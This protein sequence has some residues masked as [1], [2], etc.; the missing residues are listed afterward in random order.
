MGQILKAG[1]PQAYKFDPTDT[2]ANGALVRWNIAT[3]QVTN[4]AASANFAAFIGVAEFQQPLS[5]PIDNTVAGNVSGLLN[6]GLVRREGVFPFKTTVGESYV[7]GDALKRGANDL[8]VA[9]DG[10]AAEVIGFVN[11]P[12]GSIILGAVGVTVPIEI[13]SNFGSPT[14]LSA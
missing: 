1:N 9:L 7:H 3:K 11:L 8:T 5:S 10:G 12:D 6:M 13:K 14:I 2:I 4:L